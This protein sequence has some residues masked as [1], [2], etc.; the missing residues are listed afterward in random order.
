MYSAIKHN[1]RP[2]YELARKGI[3]VE[4]ESRKVT[5]FSLELLEHGDDFFSYKTHC[6]KGTYVRTLTEDLA[7]ALNCVAHVTYLRRLTVSHFAEKQMI[8]LETL[9]NLAKE[10]NLAALDKL[11]LPIESIFSAWP[12][13]QISEQIAYYLKQGQPVVIPRAP[14]SGL[15]MLEDKNSQFLG[16]GEII[17][18]GRVA[19]RR[20]ISQ[21]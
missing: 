14:S 6:S 4:R 5:I 11:L 13:I 3:T 18:D 8:T 16:V 15:V 12:K 10:G 2:L 19:P 9:E 20:L 7:R 17:E 21:A 1:G